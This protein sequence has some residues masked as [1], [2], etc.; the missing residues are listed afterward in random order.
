MQYLIEEEGCNVDALDV[1]EGQRLP[2][3][4]GVPMAYAVHASRAGAGEVIGLL[5]EVSTYLSL[6]FP[7]FFPFNQIAW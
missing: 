3:H 1:E 6:D 5:L 4:W 2:N 7:F